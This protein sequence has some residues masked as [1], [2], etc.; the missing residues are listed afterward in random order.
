MFKDKAVGLSIA[1]GC[2]PLLDLVLGL[3]IAFE[4]DVMK[5]GGRH[6][7]PEEFLILGLLELKEGQRAAV[8]DSEETMTIGSDC[9]EEPTR[10]K[11][12]ST[13]KPSRSS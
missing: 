4:R 9:S 7:W 6:F 12:Q 5:R 8:A 2:E 10:T 3:G 11:W 13:G 1:R